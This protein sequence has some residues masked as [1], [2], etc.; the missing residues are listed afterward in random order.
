MGPY[1]LYAMPA[2]LYSGKA[3][4]YLRKHHIDYVE[5]APG[6]ARY[7]DQVV[8]SIGR[9]IIPVLQTGD[10]TLVQDT[11]DIIDHLDA[12]VTAERSAYPSTPVHRAIAHLLELFGGE[13]LL[14]PA[15]ALPVGLRRHQCGVPVEGL[16]GGACRG[17]RR[18]H[19]G[20]RLRLLERSHAFGHRRVRR[21]RGARARDRAVLRAVPR[22]VSTPTWP[23]RPTCSAVVR[24]SATSGS[25]AR[26]TPT[27]PGTRTRRC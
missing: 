6:D 2:S 3:R 18:R 7:T 19:P 24:P 14:R 26:S 11:V 9:W 21:A 15:H 8:P 13:G 16:L 23:A 25:W 10:G 12:G 17:R 1:T 4:S 5:I 20:R 27:W 22:P